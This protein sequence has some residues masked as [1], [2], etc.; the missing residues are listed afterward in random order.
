MT[1][2]K[3]PL[4]VSKPKLSRTIIIT[5]LYGYVLRYSTGWYLQPRDRQCPNRHPRSRPCHSLEIR[6]RTLHSRKIHVRYIHTL[7]A[8][9]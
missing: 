6:I 5:E 9:M 4:S 3:A 7:L 1:G 8:C 2:F